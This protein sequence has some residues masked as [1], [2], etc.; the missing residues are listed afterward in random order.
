MISKFFTQ[1]A[2]FRSMT[3][4][5]LMNHARTCSDD[6][7]PPIL[8]ILSDQHRLID[9]E[10]AEAEERFHDLANDMADIEHALEELQEELDCE[11]VKNTEL[12]ELLRPIVKEEV[13]NVLSAK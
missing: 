9:V 6:E 11:K 13:E 8:R 2:K 1:D 10:L 4:I 5:E 3:N 12:I 7:A